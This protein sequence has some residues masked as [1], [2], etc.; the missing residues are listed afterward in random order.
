MEE[1]KKEDQEQNTKNTARFLFNILVFGSASLVFKMAWNLGLASLFPNKIPQ[2]GFMHA[3]T[4][5]TMLY[6]V[7]RVVSAG[8]MA[9]VERTINI[10][11]EE[12]QEAAKRYDKFASLFS[13]KQ[14]K[15]VD[16]DLN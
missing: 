16:K 6:I 3:F 15:E 10:L 4:W 5:L 1:E 12:L 14:D 13:K 2:I 11:V 7:A 9:E 8:Y